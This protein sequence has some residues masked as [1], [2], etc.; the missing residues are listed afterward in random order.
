MSFKKITNPKLLNRSV[1]TLIF[2]H[3]LLTYS[4]IQSLWFT[5]MNHR[6]SKSC[7]WRS[8][9]S[10]WNIRNCREWLFKNRARTKRS[11][12]FRDGLHFQICKWWGTD[13]PNNT[14]S[15]SFRPVKTRETADSFRT[16]S[17]AI[18][19]SETD[20]RINL[21]IED[22]RGEVPENECYHKT[23]TVTSERFS[24]SRRSWSSRHWADLWRWNRVYHPV[25]WTW[26]NNWC[27]YYT[28]A[29]INITS[30]CFYNE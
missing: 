30:V 25:R 20:W 6:A 29:H 13:Y 5:L 10:R 16:D 18:I 9:P 17:P 2:S 21:G 28:I 24:L 19:W 8:Q 14:W 7:Y 23:I 22:W 12:S 3:L 15:K 1:H 27:E 26:I 11:I 4:I